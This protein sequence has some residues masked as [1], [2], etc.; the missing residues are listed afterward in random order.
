MKYIDK[1]DISDNLLNTNNYEM[2]YLKYKMEKLF[3][4]NI[5]DTYI[6]YLTIKELSKVY[7]KKNPVKFIF[8]ST[9]KYLVDPKNN[10]IEK[11]PFYENCKVCFIGLDEAIQFNTQYIKYTYPEILFYLNPSS[12]NENN[13]NNSPNNNNL[14]ISI[15]E[16]ILNIK[17]KLLRKKF[18]HEKN[19]EEKLENSEHYFIIEIKKKPN[20]I[21]FYLLIKRLI[22]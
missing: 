4:I 7:E 8:Y 1:F 9:E 11:I 14:I 15:F 13:N 16:K 21:L 2:I 5:K 12:K 18:S 22:I 3:K 10:I 20:I 19:I 17:L 6:T